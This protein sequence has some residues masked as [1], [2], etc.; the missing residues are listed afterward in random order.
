MAKNKSQPTSEQ[1]LAYVRS[2]IYHQG[3]KSEA[4]GGLIHKTIPEIIGTWQTIT[5]LRFLALLLRVVF[6]IGV[7]LLPLLVRKFTFPSMGNQDLPAPKSFG[8][9]ITAIFTA[10]QNA[11]MID[12]VLGVLTLVFLFVPK[13]LDM[14][15][16]SEKFESHSPFF[17]LTAAV[18]SLP[19]QT[20]LR[21]DDTKDAIR[22]TLCALRDEM[23]LLIRDKTSPQATNITL[24]EFCDKQ[25]KKIKVSA[26]T[27]NHE[28][29]SRPVDSEKFVAY[30]VALEGRNFAEHDFKKRGNPFPPR[31]LTVRGNHDIK[32]RSVLYM[33]IVCSEKLLH[34]SGS[35]ES[36]RVVDSCVG[37]ICIHH[38][39]AYR[40]WRWGDHKRGVG[41]FADVAFTRSMPYIAI[42]EQLLSRTANRVKLESK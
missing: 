20:T 18:R 10:V 34:Q 6:A 11:T 30:Y 25:G 5:F 33:P 38:P 15:G 7:A 42:I 22:L 16:S 4:W 27:A 35:D 26:R 2:G 12:Y 17:E 24:L 13:L 14:F 28:E 1:A 36:L 23:A 40:F 19:I 9:A 8:E 39:K 31:R 21:P 32:Y 37:I 29:I 41:G 3:G